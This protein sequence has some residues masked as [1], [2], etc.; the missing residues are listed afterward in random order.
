MPRL[1]RIRLPDIPFHI[2]QRGNNRCRTFFCDADRREYLSLLE[3]ISQRYESYIHAF[4]LMSNHVHLLMTARDADGISLTMQYLGSSYARHINRTRKR[5]GTLWES[6]YKSS[7]IDSDFYCLACYRYIELN[8][9][10]AGMVSD[11]IDYSWS[12]HRDNVGQ[13]A[14][15]II[16]PH[17]T[18]LALGQSRDERCRRY[19]RLFD[20][21]LPRFA[22]DAIRCGSA[23]GSPVGSSEF[24]NDIGKTRVTGKAPDSLGSGQKPTGH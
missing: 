14:S 15:S 7:P 5:T 19:R 13:R 16:A 24:A 4:V 21:Q 10:R 12:S 9:V 17:A 23:K 2:V 11:P 22:L 18:Y 3:R 6:R 20:D 1:P 8:P